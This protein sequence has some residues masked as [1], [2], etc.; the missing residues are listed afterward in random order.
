MVS[1]LVQLQDLA[2]QSGRTKPLHVIAPVRHPRTIELI[3]YITMH[4]HSTAA[5]S[6]DIGAVKTVTGDHQHHMGSQE[7]AQTGFLDGASGRGRRKAHR[8]NAQGGVGQKVVLNVDVLLPD[9]LLSGLLTQ[10][11][12]QP[13][14][15]SVMNDL[16]DHEGML[17][18]YSATRRLCIMHCLYS[19]KQLA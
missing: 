7:G 13:E 18:L 17:C 1:S 11:S 8:A 14:L 6:Q 12:V 10:V 9:E 4:S 2:T 19:C 5:T 3:N 16:F 15:L